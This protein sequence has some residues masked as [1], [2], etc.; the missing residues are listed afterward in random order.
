ML[1]SIEIIVR[2]QIGDWSESLH[3]ATERQNQEFRLK[4]VVTKFLCFDRTQAS[5]DSENVTG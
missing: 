3:T 1:I 5:S 2:S 4:R